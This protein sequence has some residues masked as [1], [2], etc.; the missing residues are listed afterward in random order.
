MK[1][2]ENEFMIDKGYASELE[3]KREVFKEVTRTKKSL[4]LTMVTTF[5]VKPNEYV[6]QS[7]QAAVTMNA[8]FE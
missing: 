6:T 3:N 4:F 1:Y 5:G 2:T 8:L 7:I